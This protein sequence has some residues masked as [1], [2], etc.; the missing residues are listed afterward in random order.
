MWH[1]LTCTSS[2]LCVC[3]RLF[4]MFIAQQFRFIPTIHSLSQ[5]LLPLES[6]VL[7]ARHWVRWRQN[8]ASQSSPSVLCTAIARNLHTRQSTTIPSISSPINQLLCV[9]TRKSR[10]RVETYRPREMPRVRRF[11]CSLWRLDCKQWKS[12]SVGFGA[13]L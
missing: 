4:L 7:W 6:W 1:F 11:Y 8:R 12:L 9:Y 2:E 13:T 5:S 3:K 10:R